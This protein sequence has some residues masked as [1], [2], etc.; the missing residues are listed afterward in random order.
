MG[1]PKGRGKLAH[2]VLE[3]QN[4]AKARQEANDNLSLEEKLAK[5]QPGSWSES[6]ILAKIEARNSSK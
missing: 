4:S 1:R 6:K 5:Q 3:R 2:R